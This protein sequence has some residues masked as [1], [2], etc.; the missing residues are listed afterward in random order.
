MISRIL[1]LYAHISCAEPQHFIH[2]FSFSWS[3][4]VML[5][6]LMSL[7]ERNQLGLIHL[8]P[9]LQ[10]GGLGSEVKQFQ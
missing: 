9:F 3:V 2:V 5:Q 1:H 10:R 7:L 4:C 8:G 6:N